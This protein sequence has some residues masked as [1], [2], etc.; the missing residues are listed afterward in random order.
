MTDFRY[1]MTDM[2]LKMDYRYWI[3]DREFVNITI[4]YHL[5]ST[6]CFIR[7]YNGPPF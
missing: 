3:I 6:I 7:R 4:I 5:S 1:Q 2:G